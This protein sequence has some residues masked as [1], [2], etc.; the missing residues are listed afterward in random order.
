MLDIS[1]DRSSSAG[2]TNPNAEE[3]EDAHKETAT[4][5]LLGAVLF[6]LR[7]Y[8]RPVHLGC[9]KIEGEDVV[10]PWGRLRVSSYHSIH[11][12]PSLLVLSSY[13]EDYNRN[14]ALL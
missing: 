13:F 11:S 2:S 10:L 5:A 12:L 7:R 9:A 4:E 1:I 6:L 8:F 3:A 14:S